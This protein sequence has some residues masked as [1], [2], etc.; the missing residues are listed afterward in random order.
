MLQLF[1]AE[2]SI[3][4]TRRLRNVPLGCCT[5]T[6]SGGPNKRKPLD[7]AY[8]PALVEAAHR[9]VV[10][11]S[12]TCGGG[13]KRFS[14]LLPPP[15]VTGELHLGHALTCAIQDVMMRW[16]RKQG[17]E[18]LWIPGMDHAGI[19]T[20]VVVEKRLRKE[21]GVGRH[22][23]GRERFLEEIW[24]WK[25]EKGRSIEGDL[26]GL[27]S[28]MDWEREYFTMDEQ[29]S[30]AVREAF[31]RLF[32]AGLIYRDKALVNWS[33]SLESAIS[34]I[35]VE[36]VEIDGPTPVEIPGYNR[37]I[38][39]G[40]MVDVAYKVQ[41]SSQEIIISTTRPET[42]LGDVAVAVNPNDGRYEHLRGT[43]SMLWHPI[44]KEEIPLVFDESVDAEFGT[45]A[46]KITPAHDRYDF[47]LAKRH[48]LPLVEVIDCKG[49]IL[50][51]FGHFTDLPRY[52]ARAKMM[53]YLAN[54]SLLRGV[55]PHS[56]VLPVC[57][58][59][60]DVIEFLL[61]PQWFVRCQ[62]MANR[63]VEA[64]KSGQLQII[65]DHFEKEWFRWL[66]N[67]HDWC[68]SR[69]LW[70]G[71]QI[72]AF[73]IK[74]NGK[75]SWI[76]AT[77][78]DE[79]RKKAK[80]SL[81]CESFEI[82]Q[83]PDVLDTWFSSSL[84]PF[85]TLGWPTNQSSFYPLDLMET[86]HDI[87]FFWVARM[88]M[89]G[90]QLTNQLPFPKILLHGIVCDEYGRKMSKSLGN[91]IKPDQV[92]RGITLDDL[93]R[94]AQ[95]SHAQGVLSD[96]ELKKSLAGQRRMFPKG[97]PEC[98]TDALRF[99]LCSA[100][101]KNHFINFNVQECHTNKL[102]FNKIWQATR[103]TAGCVEKFGAGGERELRVEER[104][105]LTEMDRWIVSRLGNTIEAFEQALE[106]YNFHLATA[107]WKTFF[108]S[109]LCDVY[110]ETTKVHMTPESASK[111]AHHCQILQHCLSLGLHYLEVFTPFLV[112]E[113]RPHLPV[114]NPASFDPSAWIDAQLESEVDQLLE[115]CQSV[116]TAKAE[117]ARPP[118]VRKHDPRLHL[119]SKSD[120][121]TE[122]LRRQQADNVVG[123]L[124][125][126]N[127]VVL[128]ESE[129]R[130]KEQRFT[131]SSAASHVCSFG[132]VTNLE[133]GGERVVASGKDSGNSKKLVK[134]ESEL[135]RLL[136]A[137]GN[138]GYR[139][140]A[141]EAVQKKHSE[142]IKQLQL[143]IQD[144]RKIVI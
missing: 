54:V 42:L 1:G 55:K 118:I 7:T 21:C 63:A 132:I 14:M 72:P 66:E 24:K 124:T 136:A 9:D 80:S 84:L 135:D 131:V 6:C 96:S 82:T 61:R 113:L 4:F 60:K 13:S 142:R 140:S 92:I 125:L 40:E 77:S 46:V 12:V 47:E 22:D 32:E 37:K 85:S 111:A 64:V 138:E 112:A 123:Q 109:N 87:L 93:N 83:D 10:S 70:W 35:E 79:A 129:D 50:D 43:T 95:L 117:S 8:K 121:L 33:C 65:P 103:Y 18:G 91:V 143:Q 51:G 108:Y 90:Q 31:V 5:R 134:L 76:A 30:R 17:Y 52:E 106:S 88:V 27:G 100:N 62:A 53:D 99:T 126:C 69:Q 98:G 23:L 104:D 38:T 28:S 114:P 105:R 127:G 71:H 67:C 19:A 39:F 133:R 34:D 115:I 137:V 116:R 26:R 59:S 141:S 75:T 41:G 58:R 144:M 25:E 110:L 20:Q 2:R 15:N 3:H 139:K 78:L 94:E 16:K 81:K 89:L 97:I 36:N 29:Q 74:A 122:L 119:L 44:R 86:G 68:I 48:R 11:R 56:M 130:F 45:G 107:A 101:V 73:E 102:F 128:H 49:R 57:S 120:Q